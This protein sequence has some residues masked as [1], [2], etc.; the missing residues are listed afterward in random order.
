MFT[1]CAR[2]NDLELDIFHYFVFEMYL[3]HSLSYTLL[4]GS[5][6]VI[7]I[8]PHAIFNQETQITPKKTWDPPNKYLSNLHEDELA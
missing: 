4:P 6:P 8:C 1:W 3:S 5:I 7:K 2:A